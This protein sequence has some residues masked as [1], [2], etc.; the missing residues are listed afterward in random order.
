LAAGLTPLMLGWTDFSLFRH[1]EMESIFRATSDVAGK[2]RIF[3]KKNRF[4]ALTGEIARL[5]C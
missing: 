3:F 2:I 1:G 5:L 4:S